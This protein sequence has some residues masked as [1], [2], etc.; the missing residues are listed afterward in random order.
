MPPNPRIHIKPDVTACPYPSIFS[1]SQENAKHITGESVEASRQEGRCKYPEA[2]SINI[3]Q[4]T[5]THGHSVFPDTPLFLQREAFC[6]SEMN[7][8]CLII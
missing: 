3:M 8:E 6:F 5:L 4:P 1:K 7:P 2:L